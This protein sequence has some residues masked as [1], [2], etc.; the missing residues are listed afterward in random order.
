MLRRVDA[1]GDRAVGR[2]DV[3]HHLPEYSGGVSDHDLEE[4]DRQRLAAEQ[5]RTQ[6]RSR[7]QLRQAAQLV[8]LDNGTMGSTIN[9]R[10]VTPTLVSGSFRLG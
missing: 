9:G 5:F 2:G 4:A 1:R 10:A 3:G 6:V 8:V 7:R